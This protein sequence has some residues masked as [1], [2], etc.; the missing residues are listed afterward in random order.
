VRAE[1]GKRGFLTTCAPLF[2]TLPEAGS[3]SFAPAN[4]SA[5]RSIESSDEL[6]RGVFRPEAVA[7]LHEVMVGL[8][9]EG[10]DA[11]VLGCTELPLIMNDDNSPLPTLN[12][13]R[14]LALAALR[15]SIMSC[16]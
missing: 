10:C 15:T 13:T 9:D 1:R 12:S 11:T 14:L 3:S 6:V 2:E 8:K 5:T 16:A 4:P 7:R